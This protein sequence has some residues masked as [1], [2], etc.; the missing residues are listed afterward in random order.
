MKELRDQLTKASEKLGTEDVSFE[1][2][3]YIV[4]YANDEMIEDDIVYEYAI[5]ADENDDNIYKLSFDMVEN[6]NLLEDADSWVECWDNP[7][8]IEVAFKGDYEILDFAQQIGA[9][10][11]DQYEKFL[12][13]ID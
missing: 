12:K 2:N 11:N 5:N 10:N 3:G 9:I 7:S 4:V 13:K 8:Y 1:I 6:Y